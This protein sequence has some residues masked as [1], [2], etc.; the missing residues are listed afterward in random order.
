M[1]AITG[2]GDVTKSIFLKSE[3]HKLSQE[4]V[5]AAANTVKKGQPVKLNTA[6]DLIPAAANDLNHVIIGVSIHDAAAGEVATVRMKA[7]AIV[8][9]RATAALNAGPVAYDGVNGTETDF[10]NYDDDIVVDATGNT[11]VGWA[12]DDA[13]AAN[14]VIRVALM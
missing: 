11:T 13:G 12:L 3:S 14:D 6:G 7:S 2:L 9:A 1:T 10:M 4:F 8:W 5:V